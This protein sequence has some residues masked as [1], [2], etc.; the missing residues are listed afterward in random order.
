MRMAG[1]RRASEAA[2]GGFGNFAIRRWLFEAARE[3]NNFLNRSAAQQPLTGTDRCRTIL[4]FELRV[5]RKE[6]FC[7]IERIQ[8]GRQFRQ[9]LREPGD[10][11]PTL[12]L[13]S[14]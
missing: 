13:K 14:G 11:L 10:D 8:L 7:D 4:E 5:W 9:D 1:S 12:E 3:R 2:P 6:P